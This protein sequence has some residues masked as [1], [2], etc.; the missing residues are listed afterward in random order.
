M[1]LSFNDG[2]LGNFHLEAKQKQ[3]QYWKEALSDQRTNRSLTT[4]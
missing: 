4:I 1:T 3:L 2:T